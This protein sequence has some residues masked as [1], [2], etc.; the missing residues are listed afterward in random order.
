[1]KILTS[2]SC[3]T[4]V[5]LILIISSLATLVGGTLE[6][7]LK[8]T[9]VSTS[10][11]NDSLPYEGHLRI[12][13]VEPVSRWN[14]NNHEP[15]HFGSLGF[16]Y[17]NALSIDYLGSYNNT[18][19]WNGDVTQNNVMVIASVFSSD[20]YQ[21]YAYPPSKNPYNAHYVDAAAAA[22]GL[23]ERPRDRRPPA[24]APRR[25]IQQRRA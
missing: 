11:T 2:K 3:I 12:Y 22:S 6:E 10:E 16:A 13:V 25:G 23:Q 8:T 20:T 17:D 14:M 4:S 7:K 24:G 9:V 18:M 19:T 1:M 15:Y 5:V 21:A